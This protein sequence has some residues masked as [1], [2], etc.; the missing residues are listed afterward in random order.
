MN[1][2]DSLISTDSENTVEARPFL[3][4]RAISQ[5]HGH[6]LRARSAWTAR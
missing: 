4:P 3:F 6:L 5:I 1:S 2:N